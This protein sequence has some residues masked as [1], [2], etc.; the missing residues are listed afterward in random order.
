VFYWGAQVMF[1]GADV[2][3]HAEPRSLVAV[4]QLTLTAASPAERMNHGW[5]AAGNRAVCMSWHL[6]SF[7]VVRHSSAP[8]ICGAMLGSLFPWLVTTLH[9]A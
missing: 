2:L 3:N 5:T 7:S 9:F 4:Q 8:Q 6:E 1:L